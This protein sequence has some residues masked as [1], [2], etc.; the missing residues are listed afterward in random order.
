MKIRRSCIS[1]AAGPER[2]MAIC[3]IFAV[4]LSSVSCQAPARKNKTKIKIGVLVYDEGDTFLK[5]AINE[6]IKSA[7]EKSR[8]KSDVTITVGDAS[9][10]QNT[11]NDQ[12]EDMIANG[13]NVLA[14]NL[15][16]R[17]D[18]TYIINLARKNDVPVVFFNRELVRHDLDRWNRL[19]Y[20]GAPAV[21]SGMMQGEEIADYVKKHPEI[22]RNGDGSIQYV[23]IKGE[24]NHQDTI[25]RSEKS[26]S[27]AASYGLNLDR[28]AEE[29]ANWSRAQAQN[30]MS[31]LINEYGDKIELVICNNDDMALG[32]IDDYKKRG[33]KTKEL[34]AVFGVDGTAEALKCV[35]KGEL[36][37]TVYNDAISQADKI[38]ELSIALAEK[39]D[40][41]QVTGSNERSFYI[42]Y[43]KVTRDN[44][45]SFA[46]KLGDQ[47]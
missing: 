39:K 41:S 20:V 28:L 26:V 31:Q 46:A 1:S 19:Y 12:M 13:C 2:I 16:D 17:T 36:K 21:R 42:D 35:E 3:C 27:T 45:S 38:M 43:Q 6:M 44:A 23:L 7:K 4:L 47:E 10:D 9:G 32:V 33:K 34:P 8:G 15:V 22:D 11:Q 18:P 24:L 30:R 25:I 37:G 14:I 5:G 29:S 40:V